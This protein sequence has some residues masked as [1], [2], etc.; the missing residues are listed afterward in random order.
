MITNLVSRLDII[1]KELR[2]QIK[3]EVLKNDGTRNLA[4]LIRARSDLQACIS[5]LLELP[6]KE[7]K[8]ES[9]SS[10]T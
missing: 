6:K 1:D 2:Q 10:R 9:N 8:H 4:C 7:E 5:N 3:A